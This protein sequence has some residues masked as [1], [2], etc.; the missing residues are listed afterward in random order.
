M[1]K[2]KTP[3]KLW[4]LTPPLECVKCKATIPF[5]TIIPEKFFQGSFDTC[6]TCKKPLDWWNII[7]A[8]IRD[9]FAFGMALVPVGAQWAA[10]LITLRR[11][12]CFELHLP[13][14]G[15]P[16]DAR[17]L[18]I[19]YTPQRRGLF[20][21]EIL[22]N[23]PLRHTIPMHLKLYPMPEKGTRNTKVECAVLVV[24]ISRTDP[25]EAWQNLVDAFESYEQ[26]RFQS[27]VVPA[28]SAVESVLNR[29]LNDSLFGIASKEQIEDFLQNAAT[30]SYQLNMLLPALLKNTNAPKLPAHIRGALNR[31]RKLR[32]AVAHR[33]KTD[34]PLRKDETAELLCAAL[35]GFHYVNVVRRHLIS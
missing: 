5:E 30:Y 35:F 13:D 24:W 22:G 6:P 33:G 28:N 29:L 21:L 20:P 16:A 26:D 1:P 3:S 34:S 12:L 31:L 18:S 4:Q 14:Y 23:T 17:I 19:N 27:T 32:N 2:T 25:N 8:K 7:L 9:K 15:I 10:F 11:G